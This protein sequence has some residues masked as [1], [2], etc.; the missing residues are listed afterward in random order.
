M[1][2]TCVHKLRIQGQWMIPIFLKHFVNEMIR[3]TE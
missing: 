2:Q 1:S 3:V